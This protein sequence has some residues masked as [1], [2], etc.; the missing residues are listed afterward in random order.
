MEW[1]HREMIRF[2]YKMLGHLSFIALYVARLL[3]E[4]ENDNAENRI[5]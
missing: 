2:E 5:F 3:A 1:A 4:D